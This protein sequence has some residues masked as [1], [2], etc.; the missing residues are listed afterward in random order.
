MKAFG[1]SLHFVDYVVPD[2]SLPLDLHNPK[3]AFLSDKKVVLQTFA[4]SKILCRRQF[5]NGTLL[6]FS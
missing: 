1:F 5:K 3:R 6:N 2:V 4:D